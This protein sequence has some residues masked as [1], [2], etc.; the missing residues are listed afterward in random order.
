ML[1]VNDFDLIKTNEY[2]KLNHQLCFAHIVM[3][4]RRNQKLKNEYERASRTKGR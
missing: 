4:S 3:V 1:E 2:M